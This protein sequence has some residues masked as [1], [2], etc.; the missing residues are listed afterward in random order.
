MYFVTPCAHRHEPLFGRVMDG[1]V[2]LSPAGRMV[3]DVWSEIPLSFPAVTLDSWV[4]M[5][6]HFHGLLM[7][8]AENIDTNPTLGEVMKWI[9]SITTNRYIHGVRD[10]GWPRFEEHV[11]QR[12]Y[13]DHIVRNDA[14]L[15]RIRLYIEH[16]PANWVTD[17]LYTDGQSTAP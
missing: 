2:A 5:P 11:W 12:N 6:N 7:L 17:S 13:Y 16:N 1:A 4:V 9:K 3:G 14:D 8:D 10:R 15:D